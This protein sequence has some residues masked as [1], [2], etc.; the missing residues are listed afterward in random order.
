MLPHRCAAIALAAFLF[1]AGLASAQQQGSSESA[2]VTVSLNADGSRT[3]YQFDGA[4][5]T[6]VATTTSK[7]G[8]VSGKIRYKIDEAGRFA[9]G[10]VFGADDKL[11]FK[12]LYK[13][14]DA[15]RLAQETQ[16]AKDDSV[17]GKIV[18]AYDNNGRQAGYSTFDGSGKLIA[19]QA[20]S[21]TSSPA[22]SEAGRK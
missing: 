8:K 21:P 6:A 20:A 22:K 1:D 10:E 9:S 16:L 17:Q 5:R 19:K 4:N 15:G 11:R 2:R 18:Y 3:T 14:D 12:T 13:Y 7:E